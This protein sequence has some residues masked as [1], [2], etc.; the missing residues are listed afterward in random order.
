MGVMKMDMKKIEQ[1][2][3]ALKVL[4]DF[5][6]SID[7]G[8]NCIFREYPT[9]HISMCK[10]GGSCKLLNPPESWSG[11]LLKEEEENILRGL[12]KKI[13]WIARDCFGEIH[14]YYYKPQKR[15]LWWVAS[16]SDPNFLGIN[17]NIPEE[18]FSFIEFKDKESVK[19]DSLRKL[20][21]ENK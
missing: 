10:Y 1:L 11:N 14:G 3:T 19:V 12:D 20:C 8:T 13:K 5:C 6:A 7:S 2:D 17:L 15:D 21:G 4:K 18:L 16:K 9:L